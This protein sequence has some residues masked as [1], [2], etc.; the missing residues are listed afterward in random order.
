VACN[1]NMS[2]IPLDGLERCYREAGAYDQ[3]HMS[4]EDARRWASLHLAVR[5]DPLCEPEQTQL[6]Y[7]DKVWSPMLI[8]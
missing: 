8:L 4:D 3:P 2:Q 1:I 6:D 7:A 5:Q